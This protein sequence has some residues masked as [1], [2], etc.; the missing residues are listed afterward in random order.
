MPNSRLFRAAGDPRRRTGELPLP[1]PVSRSLAADLRTGSC[2]S[3]SQ[4]RVPLPLVQK[5][6][7]PRQLPLRDGGAGRDCRSED[8]LPPFQHYGGAQRVLPR[9]ERA[10]APFV[11]HHD[12]LDKL[13]HPPFRLSQSIGQ[14][15]KK[16]SASSSGPRRSTVG[17]AAAAGAADRRSHARRQRNAAPVDALLPRLAISPLSEPVRAIPPNP[18]PLP[19]MQPRAFPLPSIDAAAGGYTLYDAA[20]GF[21]R[22]ASPGPASPPTAGSPAYPSFPAS[23]PMLSHSESHLRSTVDALNQLSSSPIDFMSP[24]FA[25]YRGSS[26]GA[27]LAPGGDGGSS[28][29]GRRPSLVSSSLLS[30][31]S[32]RST[33]EGR[34]G[35]SSGA[36][37]QR[38]YFGWSAETQSFLP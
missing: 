37:E 4:K 10:F 12:E 17:R 7:Q 38:R 36:Q 23:P 16:K 3:A 28:G 6:T 20:R 34:R 25:K 11:S 30:N 32:D 18:T 19:P 5:S 14:V 15:K 26:R 22:L 33:G 2:S 35:S 24:H 21:S 13:T 31:L 27:H 9:S 1:L 8:P 29:G